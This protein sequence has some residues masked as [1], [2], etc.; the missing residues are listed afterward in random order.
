M[1]RQT[2]RGKEMESDIHRAEIFGNGGFVLL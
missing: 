2:E 1:T